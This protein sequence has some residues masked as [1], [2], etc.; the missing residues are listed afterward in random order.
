MRLGTIYVEVG[1]AELVGELRDFYRDR[2]GLAVSSEEAG[3]SVWLDAGSVRLGFH[4]APEPEADPGVVNLSF[5]VDDVD[6]M[7]AALAAGGVTIAQGPMDVP[8]GG[9]AAV[10]FDPAGHTVWLSGPSH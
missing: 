9:R 3:E 8:W 2:L 5:D 6:A 1:G 7:A 10:L 4:A